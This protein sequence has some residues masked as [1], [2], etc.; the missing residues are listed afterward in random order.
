MRKFLYT[1]FVKNWYLKLLAI[2][3]AAVTVILINL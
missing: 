2:A 3:L 1:L